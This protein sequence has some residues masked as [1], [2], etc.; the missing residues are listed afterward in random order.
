MLPNALIGPT[1]V[2]PAATGAPEPWMPAL[3]SPP[4]ATK[5]LMSPM[6]RASAQPDRVRVA[7]YIRLQLSV[8]NVIGACAEPQALHVGLAVAVLHLVR[9][10][11]GVHA[12]EKR[13]PF[14]LEEL[15]EFR[16]RAL[17]DAIVHCGTLEPGRRFPGPGEVVNVRRRDVREHR[18][19]QTNELL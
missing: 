3:I 9:R 4:Q 11:P 18:A 6:P 15:A 8:L 16:Q 5:R 19:P 1:A 17:R 12:L 7:V 13:L 10:E 2:T 14:R